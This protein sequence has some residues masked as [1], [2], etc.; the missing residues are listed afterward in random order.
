MTLLR[1]DPSVPESF[2]A[3]WDTRWKLVSLLMLAGVAVSLRR[4]ELA[5]LLA[6]TVTALTLL[7]RISIQAM[8]E[9]LGLVLISVLPLLIVMPI[10]NGTSWNVFVTAGLIAFRVCTVGLIALLITR[11]DPFHR[12]LCAAYR[13]GVPSPFVQVAQLAYRY[14]FLFAAEV[15]RMRIAQ[16]TR[17]FQVRTTMHS[18]RTLGHTLGSLFVRSADHAEQI[19]HA[20]RCRGFDGTYRTI[21]EFRTTWVDVVSFLVVLAISISLVLADRIGLGPIAW[22]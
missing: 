14:L 21:T 9:R 7:A 12:T 13:L 5:G 1:R 15:R 17:G 6:V 22:A 2:L 20:M 4:L 19:S 8:M 11:T 16:R 18:Y 10:M 3:R